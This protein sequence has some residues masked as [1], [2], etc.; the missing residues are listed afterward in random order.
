[1]SFTKR[2]TKPIYSSS[3]P[4]EKLLALID[5]LESELPDSREL[6]IRIELKDGSSG[7][8]RSLKDIKEND[9]IFNIGVDSISISYIDD[10][11]LRF[12]K[13]NSHISY[14]STSIQGVNFSNFVTEYLN[15]NTGSFFTRFTKNFW[16]YMFCSIISY[17]SVSYNFIQNGL[18]FY[19][20]INAVLSCLLFIL[21]LKNN[22]RT[23]IIPIVF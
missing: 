1:M 9:D 3:I 21:I 18:S 6:L 4:F 11:S 22:Q 7:H 19:P 5:S 17:V 2:I 16:G 12:N 14:N 23:K 15:L 10:F 8:F 20:I 13:D